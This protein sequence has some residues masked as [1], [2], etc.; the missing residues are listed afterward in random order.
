MTLNHAVVETRP[1]DAA[2]FR[3]YVQAVC[4]RF[5]QDALE[6]EALDAK[7]KRQLAKLAYLTAEQAGAVTGVKFVGSAFC[8]SEAANMLL[9]DTVDQ[10]AQLVKYEP[11]EHDRLES[12]GESVAWWSR[13]AGRLYDAAMTEQQAVAI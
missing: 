4:D 11:L 10:A 2:T 5:A 9:T 7:D 6:A 1:E 8:L 3:S 13:E 12:L